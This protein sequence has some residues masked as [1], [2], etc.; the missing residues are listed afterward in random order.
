M[1]NQ[2]KI[3]KLKH[4]Y[5]LGLLMDNLDYAKSFSSHAYQDHLHTHNFYYSDNIILIGM[6]EYERKGKNSKNCIY[7]KISL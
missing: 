2:L 5:G 1:T 6:N 7:F 4:S 3:L